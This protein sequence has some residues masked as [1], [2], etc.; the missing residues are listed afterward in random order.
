MNIAK[1]FTPFKL[2]NLTLNNRFIKTA[3][4]EGYCKNG[5]P[6]QELTDF[7]LSFAKGNAAMVTTA[8]GAVNEDGLTHENQMVIDEDAL[9]YLEELAAEIH[10]AGSAIS[11]QLTHCGF[12]TKSTRYKSK[13]PLAPS[14]VVNQYGLLRGRG[15]ARA[16]TE[17]ELLQTRRDFVRA[18]VIVKQAG[19]DAI[20]VHMGHGYL[21]SQFLTP[22]INRRKDH[23]GGSLE[24]RMRFPLEVVGDIINVVG[25]D[26][27]VLCKVNLNDDFRGGLTLDES[28][29]V[30]K[31][32]EEAGV[33]ALVLSGG[34]TSKTPFY[35]M[36]GDVPLWNMVKAENNFL[37]KLVMA[38][39]GRMIIRKYVF[40]ENFFLPLAKKV[41]AELT[42]P[43]VYVGGV[44]SSRG[45]DE[46]M[47][48]GFDL[49][50]IGRALIHDPDFLEKVRSDHNHISPCN[51]CNICVAEM[52]KSGV[53]CVL[54]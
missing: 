18:A 14:R 24:N 35:L 3:T 11:M 54:E 12:F 33:S 49:I 8:Y 47:R 37:Q 15:F 51:H 30:A 23:Y 42:M 25:D 16:M 6:T 4:Y 39:F 9:P 2:K 27:P 22:T 28:I 1:T 10:Q 43:L 5:K 17:R 19:F 29:L 41:R 36:R 20:E 50:S 48:E 46:V 52:E 21:L 44:C 53:Q 7:H 31:K 32:L 45:I 26:Y 40:E 34:Y 38:I 13:K